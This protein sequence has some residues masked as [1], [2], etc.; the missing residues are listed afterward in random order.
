[1]QL[2]QE[3]I[4]PEYIVRV[5]MANKRRRKYYRKN[6][7]GTWKPRQLPKTYKQKLKDGVY[8]MD[9][10]DKYILDEDGQRILAN[11]QSAGKPRYRKLSGNDFASGYGSPHIRAKLV[12]ELKDFYRPFMRGL[13]PI[14]SSDFP[15]WVDWHLYTT[16]P[17]RLFDLTNFWFY[18]KYFEACLFEWATEDNNGNR[19][20]FDSKKDAEKEISNK[21]DLTLVEPIIPDDNVKYVTKPGTA[22]ILHPIVDWDHR[23]FVFKIYK[24][25]RSCLQSHKIY[26]T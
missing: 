5:K 9:K 23:K 15:I 13:T 26:N 16:I 19:K 24:D 17:D 11:P 10:K 7:K 8:R 21:P 12:R 2:L 14:S 18:Y 6:K 20:Y 1:M 4:I 22:P 3:L 25:D